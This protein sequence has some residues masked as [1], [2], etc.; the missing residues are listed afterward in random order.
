MTE[1]KKALTLFVASETDPESLQTIGLL[2]GMLGDGNFGLQIGPQSQALPFLAD[3]QRTYSGFEAIAEYVKERFVFGPEW[4]ALGPLTPLHRLSRYDLLKL[5]RGR[6]ALEDPRWKKG[7]EDG[8]LGK[9]VAEY[10][11]P[12]LIGHDEGSE[13]RRIRGRS[14]LPAGVWE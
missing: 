2:K 8:K 7:Y 14:H 1:D 13:T 5:K 6:E 9:A 12:Y 10:S 3:R 11:D 4:F